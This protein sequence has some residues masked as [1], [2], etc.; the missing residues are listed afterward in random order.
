MS[1]GGMQARGLKKGTAGFLVVSKQ[2]H[3]VPVA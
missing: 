1:L 2:C 3:A